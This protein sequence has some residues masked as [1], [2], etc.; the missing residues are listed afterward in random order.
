MQLEEKFCLYEV[1]GNDSERRLHPEEQPVQVQS[2]W[3]SSTQCRFVL[4][5][6][7][8]RGK[9]S[10]RNKKVRQKCSNRKSVDEEETFQ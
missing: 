1:A 5:P 8:A 10:E 6:A 7:P 9:L 2:Q 3:A 4:R